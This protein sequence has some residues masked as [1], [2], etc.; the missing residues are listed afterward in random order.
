MIVFKLSTFYCYQYA[1]Y[2]Q[3]QKL[4]FLYMLNY[5]VVYSLSERES[6]SKMLGTMFTLARLKIV[7]TIKNFCEC[8]LKIVRCHAVEN[9]KFLRDSQ[10]V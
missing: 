9:Y 3:L 1:Q 7:S 4:C 6:S 10:L 8:H 2:H 5:L